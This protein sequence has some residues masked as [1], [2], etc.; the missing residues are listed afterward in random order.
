MKR[1]GVEFAAMLTSLRI[2]SECGLIDV[3]DD[4]S[5][6]CVEAANRDGQNQK[7]SPENVPT[8]LRVGYRN[9]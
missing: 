8:A 1:V 9:I 5:V 6:I 7:T 4:G 3:S 2:L